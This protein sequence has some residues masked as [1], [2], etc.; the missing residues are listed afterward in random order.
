[1]TDSTQ[2]YGSRRTNVGSCQILEHLGSGGMGEVY[3]AHDSRLDRRVAI[4]LLPLKEYR[5]AVDLVL[6]VGRANLL[7]SLRGVRVA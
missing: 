6:T 5:R 3:L 7:W 1:M 2:S 4:K